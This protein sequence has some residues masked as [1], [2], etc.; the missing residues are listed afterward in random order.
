M[1]CSPRRYRL[2]KDEN[3]LP[4]TD[5]PTCSSARPGGRASYHFVLQSRPW[6][7]G[8]RQNDDGLCDDVHSAETLQSLVHGDMS[9]QSCMMN[10]VVAAGEV[11]R[12]GLCNLSK[13][14][15]LGWETWV[16]DWLAWWRGLVR[17]E[18]GLHVRTPW[19][20]SVRSGG[21]AIA[22]FA[23]DMPLGT[24]AITAAS[25][26]SKSS[27]PGRDRWTDTGGCSAGPGQGCRHPGGRAA[28]DAM[29]WAHGEMMMSF[30][31]SFLCSLQAWM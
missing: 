28:E 1:A 12:H 3:D 24:Y 25:G 21:S 16:T 26:K 14:Y 4:R 13:R 10:S 23:R 15:G 5:L 7:A 9:A 18:G 11:R 8:R 27:R 29:G 19:E 2:P 17:G 20:Q 22:R 31:C 30:S 6:P